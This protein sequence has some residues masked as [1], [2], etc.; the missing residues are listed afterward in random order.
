MQVKT[1]LDESQSLP[2]LCLKKGHLL[3]C[4]LLAVLGCVLTSGDSLVS[5]SPYS[6]ST[7]LTMFGCTWLLCGFWESKHDFHMCSSST[8]PTE[9]STKALKI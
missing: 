7:G 6:R 4:W 8:L 2:C 3:H 1:Q 9:S 5:A